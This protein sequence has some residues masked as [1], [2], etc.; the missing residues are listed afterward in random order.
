M[1]ATVATSFRLNKSD[2][3]V[4]TV[5]DKRLVRETAQA[6]QRQ[7][8]VWALDE[9]DERHAGHQAAPPR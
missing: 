7:R 8:R 4:M 6:K 5:T 9:P 2:D 1:P 3:M